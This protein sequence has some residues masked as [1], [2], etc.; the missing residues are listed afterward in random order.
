[1]S[2]Q[3]EKSD[4]TEEPT[5]R[6]LR[7]ARSKGDTP[8]SKEVAG[9]AVIAAAALAAALF[10]GHAARILA[11]GLAPLVD[12]AHAVRPG[13]APEETAAVL[14]QLGWTMFAALGPVFAAFMAAAVLAAFVQNAVV[15]AP[16]R[17]TPKLERISPLKGLKRLVSADS[18][19]EFLKGLTKITAAG[20]AAA[21]VIGGEL[22]RFGAAAAIDIREAPGLLR[23]ASVTLFVAILIVM[24]V[25]TTL[26]VLW[27]RQRWT[28]EQRMTRK[29]LKDEMKNAEGDPQ[30]KARLDSIRR[31]RA[32][33]RMMQAVPKAS[34][35]IMN[36]THYAVALKYEPG[37]TP[38]PM[39][40]A[41]GVD[42]VA[43]KIRDTAEA[44]GVPVVEEPPTA[45]ALYDAVEVDQMIPQELF[46]AVAEI[47][48]RVMRA[49]AKAGGPT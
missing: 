13:A 30:I 35:V 17:I 14:E 18:L 8:A 32:R 26:D 20:G 3:P 46:L 39:C 37:E 5:E 36:P 21:L 45:R 9:F 40:V 43:L 10:G 6:K 27:R 1:M 42:A 47:I 38:A 11:R 19:M 33:K 28:A 29:E 49:D 22:E 44:A 4:K 16:D 25:I 12:R 23:D 7:E 41:K 31:D 15:F 34:V 2:D 48:T 24:A